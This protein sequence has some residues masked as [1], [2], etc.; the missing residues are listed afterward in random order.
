MEGNSC[1]SGGKLSEKPAKSYRHK[2]LTEEIA[3]KK[4]LR[5]FG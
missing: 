1:V 5:Y 3:K 4:D 2:N